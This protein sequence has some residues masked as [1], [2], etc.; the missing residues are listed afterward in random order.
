MVAFYRDEALV[1]DIPSGPYLGPALPRFAW[2]KASI[3]SDPNGSS[4]D[5]RRARRRV[6]RPRALSQCRS[7]RRPRALGAR[8]SR[9]VWADRL[10]AEEGMELAYAAAG[11]ALSSTRRLVLGVARNCEL[12]GQRFGHARHRF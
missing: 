3:A 12:A 4:N 6:Q 8:S 5:R 7:K 1:H 2:S 9:L 11:A 10:A